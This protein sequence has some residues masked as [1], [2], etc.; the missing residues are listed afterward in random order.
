MHDRDGV[1][2]TI[3]LVC[4]VSSALGHARAHT[5]CDLRHEVLGLVSLAEPKLRRSARF[6]IICIMAILRHGAIDE[7]SNANLVKTSSFNNYHIAIG[8]VLLR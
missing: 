7:E 1:F 5:F 4:R 3:V 8:S 2:A 6:G